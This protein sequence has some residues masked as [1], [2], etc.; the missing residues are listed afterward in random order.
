M[1]FSGELREAIS[2]TCFGLSFDEITVERAEK[3]KT[4]V[5]EI[6]NQSIT[7]NMNPYYSKDDEGNVSD[8]VNEYKQMI[9]NQM[10]LNSELNDT[11]GRLQQE[12]ELLKDEQNRLERRR[13][14]LE[15][16]T[17]VIKKEREYLFSI[18]N[19]IEQSVRRTNY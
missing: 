19:D 12:R 5:E 8:E 1:L 6:I 13:F 14:E 10:F 9:N 7:N 16:V 17:N 11:I 3:I 4:L 15:E 18:A 2:K